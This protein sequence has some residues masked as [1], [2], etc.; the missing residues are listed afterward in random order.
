MSDIIAANNVLVWQVESVN[1]EL[2][3]GLKE[4][5][6]EVMDPEIGLN[7]IELGLIRDVELEQDKANVKMLLT[8]PFCPYGP[9]M[10]E[11]VRRM[12]E[13]F[14]KLPTTIEMTPDLWD[15][16]YMEEGAGADWG[17]F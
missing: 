15:P 5:L 10:L 14:V 16:S 8:T 9:A 13:D 1:R 3:T 17:L 12:T 2:A 11:S 6:R 7:V 4:Q